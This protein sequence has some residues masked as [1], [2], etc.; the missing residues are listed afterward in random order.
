MVVHV[1]Q[2]GQRMYLEP[3]LYGMCNTSFSRDLIKVDKLR[4]VCDLHV[5]GYKVRIILFSVVFDHAVNH[6]ASLFSAN[7]NGIL[8]SGLAPKLDLSLKFLGCCII[9]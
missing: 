6:A 4:E 9:F 2:E 3:F 8:S 7:C 1:L 5:S